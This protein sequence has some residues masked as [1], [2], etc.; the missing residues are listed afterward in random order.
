MILE[1]RI[2]KLFSI[3]NYENLAK[4]IDIKIPAGLNTSFNTNLRQTRMHSKQINYVGPIF[5]LIK[6]SLNTLL[7][8]IYDGVGDSRID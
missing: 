8:Y 1:I 2:K 4:R 3:L 5:V 7:Q 6:N